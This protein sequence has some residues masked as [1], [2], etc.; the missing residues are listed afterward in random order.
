[1]LG[2][3]QRLFC[4]FHTLRVR[5]LRHTRRFLW[6]A[7]RAQL[8]VFLQRPVFSVS[9]QTHPEPLPLYS[10]V[11]EWPSA[12]QK[13]SLNT[14]KNITWGTG[15]PQ[16]TEPQSQLLSANPVQMNQAP[17]PADPAGQTGGADPRGRASEWA[18]GSGQRAALSLS[19]CGPGPL[20]CG[21]LSHALTK[22]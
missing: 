19:A 3:V 22:V 21:D 5:G 10:E 18:V 16:N 17:R 1:M 8:V 9:S 12:P 7:A 20:M 6:A 14:W 13:C 15:K 11:N 4:H 2:P